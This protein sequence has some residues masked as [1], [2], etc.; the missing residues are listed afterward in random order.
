MS[1]DAEARRRRAERLHQQIADLTR[2]KPKDAPDAAQGDVDAPQPR[3]SERRDA[4]CV[5]PSSPRAFVEQRMRELKRE[6]DGE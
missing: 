4:P 6:E 1:D 2:P 3:P 5:R